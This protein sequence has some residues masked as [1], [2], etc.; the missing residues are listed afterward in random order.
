MVLGLGIAG[1][2]LALDQIT[3]AMILAGGLFMGIILV[4]LILR[5]YTLPLVSRIV[6]YVDRADP[7][8]GRGALFFVVGALTCIILFPKPV[9]V[10]ALIAVT[11]LDGVATLFGIRYGRIRI[12]G[13]KTLEGT[14]SGVILTVVVLVPFL[15]LLMAISVSVIAGLIELFAPVDDNLLIPFCVCVVLT[16]VPLVICRRRYEELGRGGPGPNATGTMQSG[17]GC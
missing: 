9:V 15:S 10:P 6:R 3:S 8:P 14:L 11:V 7:L 12:F 5:G 4:D 2:V 17:P 16:A 13:N 1:M